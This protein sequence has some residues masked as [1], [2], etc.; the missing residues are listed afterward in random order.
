[1][2]Y[3]FFYQLLRWL[4]FAFQLGLSA[5][6]PLAISAV[7]AFMPQLAITANENSCGCESVIPSL[8]G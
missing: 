4:K 5:G 7:G 8:Y 2:F 3:H 6:S 1:L